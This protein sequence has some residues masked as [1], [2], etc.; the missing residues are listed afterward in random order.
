MRR[1][2]HA[3]LAA[4]ALAAGA[5]AATAPAIPPAVPDGWYVV[6][7]AG[8]YVSHNPIPTLET[9]VGAPPPPDAIP[10][11]LPLPP[12]VKLRTCPPGTYCL[13]GVARACAAGAYGALAGACTATCDGACAA[14]FWCPP[15]STLAAPPQRTC[16]NASF[17]CPPG[18]RA[19][20]PVDVGHYSAGGHTVAHGGVT[21][22]DAPLTCYSAQEPDDF[23]AGSATR[24]APTSAC[25][26]GTSVPPGLNVS[27][28]GEA[29]PVGVMT[30]CAAP[31]NSMT[32]GV[33]INTWSVYR[34]CAGG[35]GLGDA[36]TRSSQARCP[37]GS[38]CWKGELFRCPPGH[39]G[40]APGETAP[41]CAGRCPGGYV[42]AGY[43]NTA[44]TA[45]PCGGPAHYCPP[46]SAW[47]TPVDA[48]FY[49]DP[50]EP[51]RTRTQ[52]LRCEPGHY[53]PG[54][55]ER[56]ACPAGSYG[57]GSG[58]ASP[59]C[60]GLCAPGHFCPPGSV[61]PTAVR[62]GLHRGA[63]VYCPPGAA[64]PVRVNDGYYS[65]GGYTSADNA[66]RTGQA[67]CPPGSFCV[68]GVRQQCAGGS[69]GDEPGASS[70]GCAGACAAGH[71]CPPGSTSPTALRCGDVFLA[72]VEVLSALSRPTNYTPP[73]PRPDV[74]NPGAPMVDPTSSYDAGAAYR[75]YAHLAASGATVGVVEAAGDVS[76]LLAAGGPAG[77]P[78]QLSPPPPGNATAGG[79]NVTLPLLTS[80]ELVN[81]TAAVTEAAAATS[82]PT[83][84]YLALT[85]PVS[86]LLPNT[87]AAV[88][89]ALGG[90]VAASNATTA[91]W[92]TYGNDPQVLAAL[93]SSSN[94]SGAAATV[95]LH[96]PLSIPWEAGVRLR[97]PVAAV[98]VDSFA[99]V[100][101]LLVAGGPSAVWCPPGS[102]WPRSA[103]AGWYTTTNGSASS[104]D[105][106]VTRNGVAPAEPGWFAVAGVRHP[107]HAGTYGGGGGG[108]ASTGAATS[109]RHCAE[110][111]PAGH[112]CPPGSAVPVPCGDGTY[113]PPGSGACI[114]CPPPST[115]LLPAAPDPVDADDPGARAVAAALTAAAGTAAGNAAAVAARSASDAARRCRH[116]RYCCGL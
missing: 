15:G 6:P 20:T 31:R 28:H 19:P 17:Y 77:A 1:P 3:A 54:D 24:E 86:A 93:L 98:P 115:L 71:F 10:T 75:L 34:A 78:V 11:A 22:D 66:T 100:H 51:P 60:T 91:A 105:G 84:F 88:A 27:V 90:W 116:A 35:G 99:A 46:G 7:P 41:T 73:N 89:A 25:A 50:N 2:N 33:S 43:G 21:P 109:S 64:R 72:L 101:R 113:A 97:L 57:A 104:G 108:N 52:Q 59:S 76:A 12:L 80:R 63:G 94:A 23:G 5:W 4:A 30:R 83:C 16:G 67:R 29:A 65:D 8:D 36:D 92:V 61:S 9:L 40:D 112:A 114:A 110:Y 106:N 74:R 49:S 56:Y 102:A 96:L 53:C 111:C 81:A 85:L 13:D 14:G 38:F 39:Y 68:D 79:A 58:E 55:G 18:S 103:P 32:G 62:C 95:S 44:P 70:P 69:Y 26:G 48:G 37:P 107:C 42:C 82:A 87:T 47:P 45:V